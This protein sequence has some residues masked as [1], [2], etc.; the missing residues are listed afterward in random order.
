MKYLKTFEGPVMD[1]LM[2][3]SEEYRKYADKYIVFKANNQNYILLGQFKNI[4]LNGFFAK[5]DVFDVLYDKNY[6]KVEHN[7]RL[8]LY[9]L[10]ILQ[11]FDDMSDAIDGYNILKNSNKYNI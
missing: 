6:T 8:H 11:V 1:N 4:V 2:K 5:L 10:E 3:K 9:N 7:A